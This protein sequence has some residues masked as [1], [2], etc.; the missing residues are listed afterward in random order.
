MSSVFDNKDISKIYNEIK[1]VYLADNRPWILGFSGG[2]DSTCMVQLIWNA[3]TELKPNQIHKKIFIISSDTLVESPKI[4][5]QI[6]NTLSMMETAAKSAHIPIST[7][8]V[9]PLID[10]SF[11]VILLG[12][13]YPAP[14]NLFRWCTPRLKINNA[15]RFIK[16]KVSEY[17]EAIVVLGTRKDESGSRSQLM[18]LYQIEGSPLSRHSKF[19]QTYVYTPIK[20]FV[21]QDVWNYLLQNKNPWGAN[22][23]DLVVL[24]QNAN[25]EECPLVVDSTT[26]S[27]GN[28]RFGCWTCTV[29]DTDISLKNTI[30][31]GEDWMEPLLELRQELKDTQNPDIRKKVRSLKRRNGQMKLISEERQRAFSEGMADIIQHPDD[32]VGYLVPGPYTMEFCVQFLEKLLVAQKKVQA[33]GPDPDIQLILEEEIHKIQHIWRAE[34]ADWEDT[35]YATYQKI[36]GKNLAIKEDSTSFGGLEKNILGD[37]CKEKD[38]PYELVARLLGAERDH[39]GMIKHSKIFGKLNSILAEEWRDDLTQIT[40]EMKQRRLDSKTYN[41]KKNN[42]KKEDDGDDQESKEARGS[43]QKKNNSKKEDKVDI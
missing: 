7:N 21:T 5:Q 29:V 12:K 23:R 17:G 34:R 26:P 27:C 8:L 22:N 43:N 38:T 9:R 16:D 6:T 32:P 30:A 33:D 13:G 3:L 40:Q 15:D 42:S 24:Y 41:Q 39:Q 31:N 37:I 19:P 10:E 25:S 11:W 18:E 20:D 1:S 35:A 36:I 14:S 4:V 28:S 2:K